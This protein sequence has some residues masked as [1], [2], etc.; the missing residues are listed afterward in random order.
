MNAKKVS[1]LAAGLGGAAMIVMLGAG[2]PPATASKPTPPNGDVATKVSLSS[3]AFLAGSWIGTLEGGA[4][5][6][7][8]SMPRGDSI[9][10]MFRWHNPDNTTNMYELLS[11]RQEA[12][13]PVL[14]LRHFDKNFEP[15]KS[16]SAGVAGMKAEVLGPARVIFRN[17]GDT[18]GLASCE[19]HCPT[20]DQLL[21]TVSFKAASREPLKFD[22]KRTKP[23][24]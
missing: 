23:G 13:G 18:G 20:A 9:I 14:R 2:Q 1:C 15:W 4:A 19:Y 17:S 10:G 6:E 12:D 8:W 7:T 3:C 11:I 16:E 22:L 21:I 24:S 5:E